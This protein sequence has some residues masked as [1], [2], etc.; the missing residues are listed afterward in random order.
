[1]SMDPSLK[2]AASLIRH[3]N[4]LNRAE[5]IARLQGDGKWA[6]TTHSALGLVKVGNRKLA[7]GGKSAKKDDAAAAAPAGKAAPAAK[8]AAGKAAPAAK[9]AAGKAAP[10]AKAAPAKK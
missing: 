3:R 2:G 1:M 4:V 9:A 5:R 7:V 8:A 10:A 6:E